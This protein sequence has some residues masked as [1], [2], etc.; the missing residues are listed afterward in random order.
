N[1]AAELCRKLGH[2]VFEAEPPLDKAALTAAFFTQLAVGVAASIEESARWANTTPSSSGF[3]QAT[4]FLGQIGRKLSAMDLQHSRDACFAGARVLGKFF[5][6]KCDVFLNATLAH[7]PSKI[8]ELGLKSVEK[9]ALSV[10]KVV[11]PKVVLT[12]VLADIG[13]ASVE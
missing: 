11:S 8:G 1:D 2:E 3:E 12:K 7:P 10:L 13:S 4:W 9:V 6:E 5:A